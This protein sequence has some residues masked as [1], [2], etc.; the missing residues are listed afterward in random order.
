M[1]PK[2]AKSPLQLLVIGCGSVGERHLRVQDTE[3]IQAAYDYYAP[4][5]HLVPYV[6]MKGI[7]F[8]LDTIGE[9]NPKAKKIKPE[10]VVDHSILQA[11][12]SSGFV[13]Q[14]AAGR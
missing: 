8:L 5:T 2:D 3:T 1:T 12:E 9:T 14:I 10:D 7:K 6:N 11:I 13:K 4:K